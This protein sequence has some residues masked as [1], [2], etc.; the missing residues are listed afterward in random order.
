MRKVFALTLALCLVLSVMT[1]ASAEGTTFDLTACIASEPETLDPTLASSVDGATYT[2]HMFEG[3]MKYVS[4]GTPVGDD[5]SVMSVET[6]YG[7]AASYAA[8]DDGLTY[9]FTLR[10]GIV[11]SD[12]QPVTAQDFV[13]SWQR[14][15]DPANAADY[16]YL[17]DGIVLNASA[18]QGGEMTPDQLGVSAPDDKTFVVT[19]E[20]QTPYFLSLCAF[21][22]LMPLRQDVIEANEDWTQPGVMVSNGAYVISEW[23]H[24]SYIKMAKN[25]SYYDTAAIGPDTIT[26]YLSDSET[27]ILAAYQAGEYD[28]MNSI[29]T[30]QIATLKASG[31]A[32]TVPQLGTY[33]LYINCEQITDWRV[34]AAIDLSIDRDNIVE[35][36]T[37]GGQSPATGLVPKGIMLSDNAE[38][39]SVMGEAMY[40]PL[41]A[42][43]PDADLTTYF[44][45]CELAQQ[46][47]S[48][49]VA[50]GFDASVTL[51][52]A[53]NTS[54]SHKAIA[55]AV[56][57]DVY[58]VLGL[59]CT[60]SNSEWQTYTNNLAEGGFA[61]ARLGW[62]ADYNDAVTYL[63]MFVN[64]GS[65]NYGRWVNDDYTALI[66][67]I[68]ALP[69]GAE[70]DQLMEQAEQMLFSEGG[71]TVAPIYFYTSN[72]CLH[73]GVNN[74]MWTP[75]GYYFFM[76]ATQG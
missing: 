51:D 58:N 64:G 49:A 48:E 4:L 56:Q 42:M 1:F 44:G 61:L 27:S 6:T 43:Y 76:Y 2:M 10:D 22:T 30:D 71:F 54:E 20:A 65:Y 72:Y 13:Y 63:D 11:W 17:L 50:D 60:L 5:D 15:V 29:P 37:Q 70:R 74:V 67:Q 32:F 26:W 16:G 66:A 9:T 45:R 7:Q 68:K 38:W 12:G 23:T 59:N 19:L 47:L 53:F 3:L 75:L 33:Y 28:F 52:Y 34:R 14:L 62:I 31:D 69:A 55:E 39:T 35:N 41:A 21:A 40:A 36:V 8:S 57:S 73:E 18:I 46:L 24:D 25:P